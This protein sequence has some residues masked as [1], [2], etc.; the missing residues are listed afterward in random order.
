MHEKE[1]NINDLIKT[2]TVNS[3][4]G[5]IKIVTNSPEKV[6]SPVPIVIAPG[7]GEISQNFFPVQSVLS[8]RKR[9]SVV[10]DHPPYTKGSVDNNI[11]V[12]EAELKNAVVLNKVVES[13]QKDGHKEGVDLIAHSEGA[14]YGI[15]AATLHPEYYRNIIL[16]A[17]AGMVGEDSFLELLLK[18]AKKEVKFVE[19]GFKGDREIKEQ[20]ASIHKGYVSDFL[21]NPVH[22]IK[23]GLAVTK[24]DIINMLVSLRK[25]GIGIVV[26]SCSDDVVFPMKEIQDKL[27]SQVFSDES[28]FPKISEESPID[29]VVVFKGL[30]DDLLVYPENHAVAD[31]LLLESLEKKRKKD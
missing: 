18:L 12:P 1:P 16:H 23:E 22:A 5:D 9:I 31:V 20:I 2:E 21:K 4:F 19:Q 7:W 26:V 11:E 3:T 29:G 27:G 30:H 25:R 15:I 6:S 28:G 24:L 17:P 14:L 8:E 13:I 10:F